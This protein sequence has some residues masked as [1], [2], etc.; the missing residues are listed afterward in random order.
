MTKNEARL[1][2]S[3]Y[4]L[5]RYKDDPGDLIDLVVTQDETWVH[6]F[7]SESKM[8]SMQWKH[9][10]SP[11]PRSLSEFLRQGIFW[12]SQGVIMIDYLE[13]GRTLNSRIEALAPGN[14][15]KERK[16]DLRCSAFA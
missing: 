10:G 2:I 4:L 11:L 5:S 14:C 1:D 15:K 13:Q 12:D 16:I 7:E 6:H 8:Q 3:R 9:P